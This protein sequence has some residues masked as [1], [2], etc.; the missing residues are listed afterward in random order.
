MYDYKQEVR[1]EEE[2]REREEEQQATLEMNMESARLVGSV[3]TSHP[4]MLWPLLI[5]IVILVLEHFLDS[6][7]DD[8]PR[9]GYGAVAVITVMFM[10]PYWLPSIFLRRLRLLPRWVHII[11]LLVP[12]VM[13][14]GALIGMHLTDQT[15]EVFLAHPLSRVMNVVPT[16]AI[17][18]TVIAV[19]VMA[20]RRLIGRAGR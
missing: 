3:F 16:A 10:V 7:K 11:N 18:L 4:F 6:V 17:S 20:L 9:T 14:S 5:L 8:V 13:A 1:R 2:Q 19:P 15:R 12:F